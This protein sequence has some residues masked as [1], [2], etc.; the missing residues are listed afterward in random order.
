MSSVLLDTHVLIW[1][2][3]DRSKL[4]LKATKIL[5][6]A[7]EHSPVYISPI[8]FWEIGILAQ[9]R[10]FE[11]HVSLDEWIERVLSLPEFIPLT[12]DWPELA[13]S[14]QLPDHHQDPADRILIAS[15]IK[16]KLQLLS[17]DQTLKK[18]SQ[19]KVIW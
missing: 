6:D 13:L 12:L 9:K 3:T 17:K 1:W 19:A 16:Q 11:L 2:L 18:Y 8:T 15:A 4:S 10:R 7:S 14:T 5:T